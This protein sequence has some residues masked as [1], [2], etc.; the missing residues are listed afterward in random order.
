MKIIFSPDLPMISDSVEG[1]FDKIKEDFSNCLR[2]LSLMIKA[3]Y[4]AL[5]LLKEYQSG[6]EIAKKVR[7]PYISWSEEDEIVTIHWNRPN[8][9]DDTIRSRELYIHVR[10]EET[11]F[12]MVGTYKTKRET[13]AD[14]IISKGTHKHELNS[15]LMDWL[16][17]ETPHMS[18]LR[19]DVRPHCLILIASILEDPQT[20]EM[21]AEILLRYLIEEEPDSFSAKEISRSISGED[22]FM[23]S[24]ILW[25]LSSEGTEIDVKDVKLENGESYLT[26]IYN[27]KTSGKI[28]TDPDKEN[29]SVLLYNRHNKT[30]L[31]YYNETCF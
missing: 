7:G 18:L 28:Y 14:R 15:D 8:E 3:K 2:T 19:R 9:K 10:L 23:E 6:A 11:Y 4:T 29:I 21:D 17:N 30:L 26:F 5:N 25:R 1:A 20:K 27:G 13:K 16:V 24:S 12:T 31:E 22:G